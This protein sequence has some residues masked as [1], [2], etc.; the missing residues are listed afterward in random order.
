MLHDPAHWHAFPAEVQEWLSLQRARSQ[1]PGP[2]GLL[3]ETFP[4]GGRWYMVVYAFE[5]RNAHQTLGMLLTKRLE[6]FG[7][8]PL[9]FVATD[10]VL[11][12]WSAYEPTNLQKLFEEDMLGDDLEAWMAES[13]ML[14]RT[15][16]NVA[17]IAGLIPRKLPGGER[18]GAPSPLTQTSS[19]TCSANTSRTMS[20]SAP[21]ARTPPVASS[22]S[23]A[24]RSC[25]AGRRKT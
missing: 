23:P 14:R 12:T 19:M 25:S 24:S 15:F 21:P 1:L 11:A 18:T 8:G 4:R 17:V 3:V 2:D 13:S 22:T 6:R 7:A 5:G 20:C 16:R 10:Y 9:G